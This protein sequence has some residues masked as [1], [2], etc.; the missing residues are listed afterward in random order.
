MFVDLL[1]MFES[2]VQI[3][4][5]L[6]IALLVFGPNKLPEIGKQI[7]TALREL[8]KAT[9]DVVRSF[10][11]DHE[12]DPEYNPGSGTDYSSSSYYNSYSSYNPSPSVD[13]TDYT[14]VGQPVIEP[15]TAAPEP[16]SRPGILDDYAV[17]GAAVS[18]AAADAGAPGGAAAQEAAA[19]A[20]PAGENASA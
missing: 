14:I 9:N 10:N 17:L 3:G 5:V 4:I 8:R 19:A 6:L 1:A 18:G 13:L 7:G 16:Y 15:A 2:P 11:V 12:P 20:K